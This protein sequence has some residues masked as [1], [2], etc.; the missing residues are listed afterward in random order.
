VESFLLYKAGVNARGFFSL[1]NYYYVNRQEYVD[2]LNL[3]QMRGSTDLMP[4]VAFSLRGLIEELE[5]VHEDVLA[6]VRVIAFRDYARETL[7]MHD[8]LGTSAGER[9]LRLLTLMGRSA[10]SLKELR[11]GRHPLSH[12]YRNV[13][14]RTLARDV[15]WL[16]EHR[17]IEVDGDELRA[18]IDLMTD[19]TA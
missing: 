10:V 7:S 8:R 14:L 16:K 2:H 6:E 11:D 18:R 17:L 1:A 4:F 12:L 5:G 19:F 15:S 3:V 13:S 9:Q